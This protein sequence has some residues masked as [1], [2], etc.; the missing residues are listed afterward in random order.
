V[1]ESDATRLEAIALRAPRRWGRP[2]RHW[3][4]K[5]LGERRKAAAEAAYPHLPARDLD[6]SGGDVIPLERP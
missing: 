2:F 5:R 3:A 4:W 1:T 6:E